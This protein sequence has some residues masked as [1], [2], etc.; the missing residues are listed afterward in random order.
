MKNRRG[1]YASLLV[2][3]ATATVFALAPSATA[4]DP[5]E[6][7]LAVDA[8]NTYSSD[9]LS[10]PTN[11]G[12]HDMAVGG[13]QH[14]DGFF[15]DCKNGAGTFGTGTCVNEGFSAQSGP[16]GQDPKGRV[17]ATFQTPSPLKLRGPVLCLDVQANR[18]YM[19]VLQTA[20][21]TDLGF[22]P[23]SMFLLEVVD[24]GNPV[25]GTPP[26]F[27]RNYGPTDF[28]PPDNPVAILAG[29]P[30]GIPMIDMPAQLQKGN[31]TVRD[32]S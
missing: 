17:S 7:P 13:G 15:P 2:G 31:L 3:L 32:V 1:L 22:P 4:Y 25:L 26:D 30:C 28:F 14:G 16:A 20:D 12:R 23:N 21:A 19:L 9:N 8:M 5:T 24:N 29:A 10:A 6:L 18:A 11:D 27:I